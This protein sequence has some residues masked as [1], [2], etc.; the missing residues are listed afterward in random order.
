MISDRLDALLVEQIT[1]ELTAHQSYMPG[2]CRIWP[3]APD[4]TA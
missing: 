1:S 4:P 2:I 3:G